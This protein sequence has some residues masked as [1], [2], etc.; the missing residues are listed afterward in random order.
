MVHVD[1]VFGVLVV[2]RPLGVISPITSPLQT[3]MCHQHPQSFALKMGAP[4]IQLPDIHPV[5]VAVN[6]DKR[7]ESLNGG[8][9]GQSTEISGMPN[10]VY[11]LQE[12]L[13]I[14]CE[15]SVSV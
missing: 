3:N 1:D 9:A 6:P 13:Y 2:K 8:S 12:S 10:L 5:A 11:R 15:N 14:R 4:G 7:L